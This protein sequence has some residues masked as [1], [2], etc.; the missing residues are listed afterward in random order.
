MSTFK[1]IGVCLSLVAWLVASAGVEVF[2]QGPD[3][4]V[5]GG[6][7]SEQTMQRDLFAP[8]EP[9]PPEPIP[10]PA[11]DTFSTDPT[12]ET[13]VQHRGPSATSSAGALPTQLP[14][15]PGEKAER[16]VDQASSAIEQLKHMEGGGLSAEAV[17]RSAEHY[18]RAVEQASDQ[19]R[20]VVEQVNETGEGS[21]PNP[22]GV[23]QLGPPQ[24]VVPGPVMIHLVVRSQPESH[25]ERH[26]EQL[27]QV[28]RDYDVEVGSVLVVGYQTKLLELMQQ[29]SPSAD[30][31]TVTVN[32]SSFPRG[33][34][35]MKREFQRADLDALSSFG[36]L[37]Y[38]QDVVSGWERLSVEEQQAI[39]DGKDQREL[40]RLTRSALSSD[41]VRFLK[42]IFGLSKED[43]RQIV[44]WA[45]EFSKN[46]SARLK[47]MLP[48]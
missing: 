20:S 28:R 45:N 43:K 1:P 19:A 41:T 10:A 21:L 31:D 24:G 4:D 6:F 8:K 14:T 27:A 9:P 33:V 36:R 26:L 15:A 44:Q 34:S 16:I 42:F 32:K 7:F 18:R 47:R 22:R 12:K 30:F 29:A 46:P 13:P 11:R 38:K 37:E 23:N 25:L 3:V 35:D 39:I 5:K 2:A 40:E 17:Q 48:T